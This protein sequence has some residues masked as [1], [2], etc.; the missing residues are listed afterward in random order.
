MAT[1]GSMSSS[2]QIPWNFKHSSGVSQSISSIENYT[3]DQGPSKKSTNLLAFWSTPSNDNE[4]TSSILINHFKTS[5]KFNIFYQLVLLFILMMS[6][7]PE[8]VHTKTLDPLLPTI[9]APIAPFILLY[10]PNR[11]FDWFFLSKIITINH[12]ISDQYTKPLPANSS[13]QAGD[14]NAFTFL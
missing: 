4:S 14:L 13:F 8:S 3:T 1:S 9:V 11:L 12:K 6:P 10:H 2:S 7:S 5:I